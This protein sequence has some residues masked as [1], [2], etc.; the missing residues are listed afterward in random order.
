MK[1]SLDGG[2]LMRLSSNMVIVRSLVVVVLA[3]LPTKIQKKL[4]WFIHII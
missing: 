1:W 4:Q 3:P 2:G